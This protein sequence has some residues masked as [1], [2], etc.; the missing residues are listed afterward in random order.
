MSPDEVLTALREFAERIDVLDPA[1]PPWAYVEVRLDGQV[2]R[3]TLR[4]PVAQALVNAL[5]EYHDPRDMGRCDHC[6]GS[7]LDGNFLCLDCGRPNGLFGQMVAERAA[8]HAGPAAI[9]PD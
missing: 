4:A 9:P 1:A 8:R 6:G 3:L 5:R 7:R 2:L